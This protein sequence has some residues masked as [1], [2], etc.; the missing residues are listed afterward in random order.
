MKIWDL[1]TAEQNAVDYFQ[2]YLIWTSKTDE[3]RATNLEHFEVNHRYNFGDPNTSVHAE[4]LK[5]VGFGQ[6]EQ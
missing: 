2:R 5:I 6:M 3:L 4:T 1:F